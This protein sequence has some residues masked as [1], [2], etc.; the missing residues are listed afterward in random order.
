MKSFNAAIQIR[1]RHR[2]YLHPSSLPGMGLLIANYEPFRCTSY[3]RNDV[4]P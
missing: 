1:G 4:L 3:V 2:S